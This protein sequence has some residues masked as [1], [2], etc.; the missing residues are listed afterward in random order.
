MRTVFFIIMLSLWAIEAK[1]QAHRFIYDVEYK[2]DSTQNLTTKENYH[3]DIDAKEARYYVRDFFTA[4]S[5]INNNLP[6]RK[7]SKLAPQ[8]S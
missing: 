1:S 6:F 2:K 8:I 3:L 4:D 7:E 5:L